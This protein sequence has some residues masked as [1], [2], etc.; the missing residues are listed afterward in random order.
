[1][2]GGRAEARQPEHFCQ[3][4]FGRARPWGAVRIGFFLYEFLI[5][6]ADNSWPKPES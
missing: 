3:V 5:P 1:M 4:D 2:V 6:A